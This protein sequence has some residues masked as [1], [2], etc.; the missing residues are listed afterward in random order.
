[1]IKKIIWHKTILHVP[2][3]ACLSSRK[4]RG[5]LPQSVLPWLR[6]GFSKEKWLSGQLNKA[7]KT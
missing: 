1:M 6:V 4:I 7:G 2:V 5:C 3:N